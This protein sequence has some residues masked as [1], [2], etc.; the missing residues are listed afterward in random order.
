MSVRPLA[1]HLACCK[2]PDRVAVS[3]TMTKGDTL[4]GDG[5]ESSCTCLRCP[6]HSSANSAILA[7]CDH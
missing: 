1:C 6:W 4:R 5:P 7:H 3:L 2:Y